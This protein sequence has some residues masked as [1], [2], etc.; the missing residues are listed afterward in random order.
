MRLPI[1]RLHDLLRRFGYEITPLPVDRLLRRRPD[2]VL[3]VGANEGQ[4]G[5]DLRRRGFGGRIV[6]FEP[7]PHV[8]ERLR[9]TTRDDDAWEI[10]NQALGAEAARLPMHVANRDASS[11]IL[12]PSDRMGDFADFLTFT[13][14]AEVDVCRLD[15]RIDALC[16]PGERV[17]MKVDVQGYESAVLDGAAAALGRLD[18]LML[19]LSFTPLYEGEPPIETLVARLRTLGFAPA[20][21]APAFVQR[22]SR[23][24]LQ[25]DVLFIR[26]E[27]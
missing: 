21:I 4:F 23:R 2:V 18:A 10:H 22:P 27:A 6:S 20:Y 14:S 24:W 16:R 25:A 15:D 11:S 13:P 5:Q 3:D 17:A 12:P 19:E 9:A 8:F 7:I 26:D 1:G